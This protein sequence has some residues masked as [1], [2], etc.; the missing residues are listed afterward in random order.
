MFRIITQLYVQWW[1]NKKR[2]I[3]CTKGCLYFLWFSVMNYYLPFTTLVESE[4][5]EAHQNHRC[6]LFTVQSKLTFSIKKHG[7]FLCALTVN[8]SQ[9]AYHSSED[10]VCASHWEDWL[11][12]V[13]IVIKHFS[14]FFMFVIF[15]DTLFIVITCWI[16]ISFR[17]FSPSSDSK[18]DKTMRSAS[19]FD[20]WLFW[21]LKYQTC[22]VSL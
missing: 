10:T 12:C 18:S 14:H 9:Y 13:V 4:Y 3:E 19:S 6:I 15:A 1:T 17:N 21:W 7:F 20:V 22:A 5:E 16:Y 2:P 8:T 11:T